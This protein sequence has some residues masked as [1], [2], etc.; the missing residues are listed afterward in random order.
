MRYTPKDR[1]KIPAEKNFLF[2]RHSYVKVC[3]FGVAYEILFV[4]RIVN[5]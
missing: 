4:K 3:L 5:R 2:G 1:S